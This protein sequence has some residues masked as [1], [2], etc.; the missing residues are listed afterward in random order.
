MASPPLA[1]SE[2]SEAARHIARVAAARLFAS[3]VTKRRRSA[4]SSR[5]AGVAK[6]TLYYYFGS[7]E[8][9]PGP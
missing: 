4:R 9:W 5:A 2:N 1:K 7:K 8:G 3:A 6:P